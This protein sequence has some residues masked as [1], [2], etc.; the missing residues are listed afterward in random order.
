VLCR[1]KHDRDMAQSKKR[2]T[3][4]HGVT[5]GEVVVEKHPVLH[6]QESVQEAG[7]TMRELEAETL[8]VS[9]GRRL[10]GVVDQPH[11]DRR[12]A[13]YGHDP[14]ATRVSEYMAG[15][16]LYC[17]EDEDCATALGKMEERQLDRLPVV[18]REMRIV[19]VVT[20]ADLEGTSKK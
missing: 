12:A 17:F 19:G 9:E 13:G 14:K 15:N 6:P 1:L 5:A 11:P 4:V 7:D 2:N 20:R 8:P 18:D 10:V 3:P 16:V